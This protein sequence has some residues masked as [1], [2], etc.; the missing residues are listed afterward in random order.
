MRWEDIANSNVGS[1]EGFRAIGSRISAG[2]GA[3]GLVK[4]T[5]PG[6]IDWTSVA[7]PTTAD[8]VQGYE[9]WRFSDALQAVAPVYLRVG[10][11]S[12]SYVNI[13]GLQVQLGTE[14]DGAGGLAG[15]VTGVGRVDPGSAGVG[16]IYVVGDPGRVTFIGWP[17]VEYGAG[18][19]FVAERLCDLSGLPTADGVWLLCAGNYG[20]LGALKLS[21]VIRYGGT[22]SVQSFP[23]GRMAASGMPPAMT[24]SSGNEVALFP[25]RVWSGLS[26]T[27]PSL[28][29]ATYFTADLAPRVPVQVEAWNGTRRAY[30]PMGACSVAAN[31]VGM[32]SNA[33]VALRWD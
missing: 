29:V 3:I 2:L 14:H 4:E 20:G 32:H 26:E 6:Q 25:V 1:N 15:T 23:A 7:K 24:G 19:F 16:A 9:V 11:G 21:A 30:Y 28:A 22:P 13:F 12:S 10:Y 17:N 18:H 8:T 31:V 27:A 33:T 5:F